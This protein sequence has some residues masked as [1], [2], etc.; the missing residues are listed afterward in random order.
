M[1][2]MRRPIPSNPQFEIDH[3]GTVWSVASKPA[4]KLPHGSWTNHLGT[5]HLI[6]EIDGKRHLVW[7]LLGSV[8]HSGAVVLPRNGSFLDLRN[9]NTIALRAISSG[10]ITDPDEIHL[11]WRLYCSGI[12]CALMAG[13]SGLC[14]AIDDFKSVVK[15]ILWAGV[16]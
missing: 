9:T 13:A 15:D 10:A 2:S 8:I 4:R 5:I 11:I 7:R 14:Y 12:T 1:N 3:D 6:V 16:R